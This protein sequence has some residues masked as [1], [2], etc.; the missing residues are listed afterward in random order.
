MKHS[1]ALRSAV[2]LTLA[3]LLP[4]AVQ[5]DPLLMAQ[6]YLGALVGGPTGG[7]NQQLRPVYSPTVL[8]I[9]DAVQATMG[10]PAGP[11][12]APVTAAASGSS[13]VGFGLMSETSVTTLS[14]YGSYVAGAE[15]ERA[16]YAFDVVTVHGSG[17]ITV[18]LHTEFAGA[19]TLGDPQSGSVA[20][21]ANTYFGPAGFVDDNK[22]IYLSDQQL[23]AGQFDNTQTGTATVA[24][25]DSFYII[26]TLTRNNSQQLMSGIDLQAGRTVRASTQTMYGDWI[27]LSAGASLS[28]DSG[29]LYTA[30]AAVPEPSSAALG[31]MGGVAML[32]WLKRRK[33]A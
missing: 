18:T 16:G 27:T 26:A 17:P 20:A 10:S 29:W 7:Y 19:L 31:L 2:T 6:D 12:Y 13:S 32:A 24:D 5:A 33:A 8:V 22:V 21:R 9:S 4:A 1:I 15:G 14:G 30:P 23:A 25:G 3:A 11:A 28:S